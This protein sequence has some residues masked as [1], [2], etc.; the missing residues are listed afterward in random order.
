MRSKKYSFKFNFILIL[1][2]KNKII[3]ILVLVFILKKYRY[4]SNN[5]IWLVLKHYNW[6]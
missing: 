2:L 1:N 5:L 3:K 4:Y 6:S